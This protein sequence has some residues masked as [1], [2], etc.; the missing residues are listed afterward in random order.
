MYLPGNFIAQRFA[1]NDSNFLAYPLI[2]MKIQSKTWIVFL[3]NEL[4]GLFDR[5]RSDTTL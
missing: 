5:L 3:D 2:R 1:G 4:C